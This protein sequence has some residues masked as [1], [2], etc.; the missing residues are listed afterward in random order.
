MPTKMKA[1][2]VLSLSVLFLV[3]CPVFAEGDRATG[4]AADTSD[5]KLHYARRTPNDAAQLAPEEM[6]TDLRD[7]R[8]TLGQLKQQAVNLFLEATR[9][10]VSP[11]DP[12]LTSS[13]TAI[14]ITMLQENRKYLPP[15]KDWLVFYINSMEPLVQL[16]VNDIN[17]VDTNGRQAPRS[18][19]DKID[20]LW[21]SWQTD[22]RRI[23]KALDEVYALI[24][25]DSGTNI[26]LAK[27][28]LSIYDTVS[29]LE[30]IRF[31]AYHI[32]QQEYLAQE[33]AKPTAK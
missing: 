11:R 4:A 16:M 13:P 21:K 32:L 8:L 2:I 6:L 30:E 25:P 27:S 19:S 24:A 28:A 22:V 31:K 33:K 20:P 17:D 15:R 12:V 23:N 18:I 26:P 9:W 7:A 29:Q 3:R 1:P 14:S 5:H 10:V